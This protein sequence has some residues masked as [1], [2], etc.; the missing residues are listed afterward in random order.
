VSPPASEG[1]TSTGITG[2]HGPTYWPLAG[3]APGQSRGAAGAERSELALDGTGGLWHPVLE[4]RPQAGAST[5]DERG[6]RRVPHPSVSGRRRRTAPTPPGG[7]LVTGAPGGTGTHAHRGD[8]R[9]VDRRPARRTVHATIDLPPLQAAGAKL[10]G[11]GQQRAP[12]APVRH[13]IVAC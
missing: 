12:C 11:S 1:T 7:S 5:V 13:L 9:G 2:D 10:V 8:T 6:T 4:H 3:G